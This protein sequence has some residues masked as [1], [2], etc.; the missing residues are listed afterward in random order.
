[1]LYDKEISRD[2]RNFQK[3]CKE[4]RQNLLQEYKNEEKDL[5][6]NFQRNYRELVKSHKKQLSDLQSKTDKSKRKFR[7]HLECELRSEK[8]N[9]KKFYG[10]KSQSISHLTNLNDLPLSSISL[11]NLQTLQYNTNSTAN[12]TD[13]HSLIIDHSNVSS[14]LPPETSSISH[15]FN[16][17]NKYET[18]NNNRPI[19]LNKQLSR[20]DYMLHS[21]KSLY[22]IE[23]LNNELEERFY[24]CLM[25]HKNRIAELE[26]KCLLERQEL[27]RAYLLNLGELKQRRIISLY[28]LNRLQIKTYYDIQRKWLCEIHSNEL[29]LRNHQNHITMNKLIESQMNE[30]Q[31]VCKLLKQSIHSY[32]QIQSI[33]EDILKK[34]INHNYTTYKTTNNNEYQRST[35]FME[36]LM[37]S[38]YYVNEMNHI[39]SMHSSSTSSTTSM[40]GNSGSQ[41]S[42]EQQT[43]SNNVKT[44]IVEIPKDLQ[45]SIQ[46]QNELMNRAKSTQS[47]HSTISAYDSLSK[48]FLNMITT[49][50]ND[51][52][53]T[54]IE[55]EQS[56]IENLLK[57][58]IDQLKLL[59]TS[60]NA[61]L[62]QCQM[63]FDSRL[64]YLSVTLEANQK[65]VEHEFVEEQ[66]RI[67]QFYFPNSNTNNIP[68]PSQYQS[69]TFQKDHS[70]NEINNDNTQMI[71]NNTDN[72]EYSPENFRPVLSSIRKFEKYTN[73]H[74]EKIIPITFKTPSSSKFNSSGSQ[75]GMLLRQD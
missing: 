35:L 21:K 58:Q 14:Q 56:V 38:P 48:T 11:N 33:L 24:H 5:N 28:N 68:S 2:I 43:N 51:L 1:M 17:L 50:Q 49:R 3:I 7:R 63:D 69:E 26:W 22:G 25:N 39:E 60:E 46:Q 65:F 55:Q 13:N 47:I 57:G 19:G 64:A 59:I 15:S 31:M 27:R 52:W 4:R 6:E 32:K 67:I 37:E 44:K 20:S 45:N 36:Q 40:N 75:S 18:R 71:R 41:E 30:R 12:T 34:D 66:E 61:A 74:G 9:L 53:I 42:N 70:S 16:H 54:I 73:E 62:K 72:I 29:Q 8:K 23:H 10:Q